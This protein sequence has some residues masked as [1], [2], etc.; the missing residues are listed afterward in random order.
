MKVPF[1]DLSAQRASLQPQLSEEILRVVEANAFIKGPSVSAFEASF[2]NAIGTKHCI[3]VANGTDA[4]YIAMRM[5][6]IG[7]GDEIITVAN[8]WISTSEA[9]TQTGA[10]PVFVDIEPDYFNIDTERIEEKITERT[11]ALL[12]VHLFGQPSN[13]ARLREICEKHGL[14]LIEDCAQAHLATFQDQTVGT[15]GQ[16][17]TFSFYPGKN[18]GAYGDAGAVCTNDSDVADRIRA[19]A[20]HGALTKHEHFMEGINSRMDGIQG[21]VL[22]L[23]LPHLRD[24]TAMR[25]RNAARFTELLVDLPEVEAPPVRENATHVFHVYCIRC[26]KRD[27][28]RRFLGER[29][30]ATGI[31]YPTPLPFLPAYERFGFEP[32][33]F[34]VASNYQGRMLSLPMYPELSSEQIEYV[35]GSIRDFYG[36]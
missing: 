24:W 29:E 26:E 23:K 28:L 19:F 18:L 5:L 13:V 16:A 35:A 34:P 6:G 7:D 21:A 20:N 15:F 14:L 11:K 8:S 33:D 10:T 27:E 9:I 12:P 30:I 32:A 36:R 1:V 25:Q 2:A 17:S 31:H 4:L 3:A 22:G